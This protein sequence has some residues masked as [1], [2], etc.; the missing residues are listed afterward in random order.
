MT[1]EWTA[2]DHLQFYEE[3]TRSHP[4]KQPKPVEYA[5]GNTPGARDRLQRRMATLCGPLATVNVYQNQG[6]RKEPLRMALL[7]RCTLCT[8]TDWWIS[9]ENYSEVAAGWTE[10]L[11]MHQAQPAPPQ[12]A[13]RKPHVK[14]V[15]VGI[16]LMEAAAETGLK[17]KKLKSLIR[18]GVLHNYG[19]NT[20]PRVDPA[21]LSLTQ[22][23]NYKTT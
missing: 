10:H 9:G 8:E 14:P 21:Q 15:Y 2:E 23:E 18:Q 16:T 4:P 3:W 20:T 11:N 1:D 5:A 17:E 13:P 7:V 6:T 19:S 12:P 22:W